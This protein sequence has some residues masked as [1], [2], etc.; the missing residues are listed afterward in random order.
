MLI[1]KIYNY[2]NTIYVQLPF[3]SFYGKQVHNLQ[4]EVTDLRG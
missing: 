1:K 4:V 3:A 2:G